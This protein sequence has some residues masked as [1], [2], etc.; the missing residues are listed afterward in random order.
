MA[1]NAVA[2]GASVVGAAALSVFLN[3]PSILTDLESADGWCNSIG[4]CYRAAVAYQVCGAAGL[5]FSLF[6]I[7]LVFLA[8]SIGLFRQ[9]LQD[10]RSFLGKHLQLKKVRKD[11]HQAKSI[12]RSMLRMLARAEQYDWSIRV[13]R[14]LMRITFFISLLL[15][16]ASAL[17]M[18]FLNFDMGASIVTCSMLGAVM[19]AIVPSLYFPTAMAYSLFRIKAFYMPVSSGV[20]TAHRVLRDSN[21]QNHALHHTMPSASEESVSEDDEPPLSIQH[22]LQGTLPFPNSPVASPAAAATAV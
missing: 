10:H 3:P 15:I 20:K 6:T 5:A 8:E 21:V 4:T 18:S 9:T 13:C 17:T 1:E 22:S 19:L 2:I 11:A 12:Q 7:L 14:A 16:L